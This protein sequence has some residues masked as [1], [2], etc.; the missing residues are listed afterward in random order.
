MTKQ[1][2]EELLADVLARYADS[3]TPRLREITEAAVDRKSVV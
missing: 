1:A 3:P 2:H